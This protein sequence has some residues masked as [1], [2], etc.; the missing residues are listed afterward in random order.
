MNYVHRTMIVPAAIVEQVRALASSFPSTTGMWTVPL[1]AVGGTEVTH[2]ISAGHVATDMAVL[3]EDPQALAN[4]T[5]IPLEQAEGILGQCIVVDA[6][7]EQV[8]SD[9][10]LEVHIEPEEAP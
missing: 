3:M 9:N 1:R 10:N 8:L 2:Y 6:P 5:G 4:A 7:W